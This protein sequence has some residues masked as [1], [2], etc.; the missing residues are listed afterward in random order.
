MRHMKPKTNKDT[1]NSCYSF[2]NVMSLKSLWNWLYENMR[3]FSQHPL[4][5]HSSCLPCKCI[6]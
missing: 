1:K 4:L 6:N 2:Y 3:E 5:H